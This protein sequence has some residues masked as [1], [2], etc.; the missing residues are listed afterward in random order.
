MEAQESLKGK[1][2]DLHEFK[3]FNDFL[4]T[5]FEGLEEEAT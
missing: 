4:G 2:V 1:S 3:G 5:P